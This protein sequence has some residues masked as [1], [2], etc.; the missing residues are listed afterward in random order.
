MRRYLW[1]AAV[2]LA[3]LVVSGGR[4]GSSANPVK[5][6][7]AVHRIGVRTVGGVSELYDRKTGLRLVLRGNNYH[8]VDA[9]PG[10]N[11]SGD[12]R[13]RPL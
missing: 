5:P 3:V 10:R 7:P 8:R 1:V 11:G 13:G 9:R 4:A 6:K 12:V 2:G